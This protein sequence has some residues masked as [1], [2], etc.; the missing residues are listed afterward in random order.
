[1]VW[2]VIY[3][4]IAAIGFVTMVAAV[5]SSGDPPSAA[6]I[7]LAVIMSLL[8]PIGLLVLLGA[9][10]GEWHRKRSR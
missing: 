8:W 3:T 5:T 6:D 7:P 2:I 4:V 1:M 9:A 10:L